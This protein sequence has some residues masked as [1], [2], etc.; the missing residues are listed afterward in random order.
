MKRT[1]LSVATLA[2]LVACASAPAT[3]LEPA[4]PRGDSRTITA[5]DITGATQLNLLD[6]IRAER[7]L[8]LKTPSGRVAALT[9]YSG[10]TRLGGPS[11][12]SGI[13]LNTVS[14][15]RYFEA[16]AAQQRFNVT[17]IGPVIQV[18]SH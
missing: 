11:T 18:F 15:V 4:G 5:A 12:L 13:S 16:S 7:P 6:F 8:W 9:V 2:L 14:L 3:E 1:S 17:N 10:D